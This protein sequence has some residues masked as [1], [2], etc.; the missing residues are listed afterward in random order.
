MI[1]NKTLAKGFA[2]LTLLWVAAVTGFALITRDMTLPDARGMPIAALPADAFDGNRALND[3]VTQVSFGPRAPGA[4]GHASTIAYIRTELS[5]TS[6]ASTELQEW[7]EGGHPYTNI[8]ARFSPENPRRILLATHYDSIVRAWRDKDHANATMPGAN[9][10]ASGVALLLETARALGDL[11]KTPAGVDMV[12][13]DGEEGPKALGEGDKQWR[14]IGSPYF[15]QH[16]ESWY[17]GG[18]PETA[19]VFD[20]VC[21]RDLVLKPEGFS[22]RSARNEV[23]R[24]WHIGATAYPA[25]FS[26]EH[27]ATPIADDQRPLQK[28]GIPAFLVIG[29]EYEPWYDTTEDTPDKC[30]GDALQAVGMTLLR[31]IYSR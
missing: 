1:S 25:I 17:G 26:K 21:Y 7:E 9:N 27:A 16:M 18:K 6:A 12:F 2:C 5:K 14:P 19:A 20:M 23:A 4:M 28:A 31:Y 24:F 11:P 22:I 10:S 30:S 15:V 8:I 13:F 3:I 29:F